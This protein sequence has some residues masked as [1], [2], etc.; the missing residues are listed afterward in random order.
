MFQKIVKSLAYILVSLLATTAGAKQYPTKAITLIVPF[1]ST[2][3]SDTTARILAQFMSFSLKQKIVIENISGTG[4]TIGAARAAQSAPDGY[5]LFVHHIGHATAPAFYPE[6]SYDPIKDFEPIGLINDGAQTF[7]SRADFPAKDFEEFVAYIKANKGKVSMAN[8]GT[9][10]ASHLCG[11]LFQEAI[12]TEVAT[13]QFSGTGPAMRDLLSGRIDV[14][15]DQTTNT[16]P[17]IK[18]GKIKAYAVTTPKRI[19]ILPDVPTADEAGLPNFE[20]SV[21]HALYA[22]KGTPKPIIDQLTKALQ[23]ALQ[24]NILKLRYADLGAE[25][26]S[27]DRATPEALRAHLQSEID[28]WGPI[29]R[30]AGVYAN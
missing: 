30:K 19:G 29:I 20:I 2:G 9:G 4:G 28:R 18:S 7:V 22:P 3:P 14:M 27:Q 21:W 26:V 6:L 17:H 5:T 15:C 24:N 25:A 16:T 10:S 11:L 12:Q 1:A 8:A 23:A 13:V